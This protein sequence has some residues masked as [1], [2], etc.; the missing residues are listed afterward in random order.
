MLGLR[1]R[2]VAPAFHPADLLA[3][4]AFAEDVLAHQILMGGEQVG[5]VLDLLAEIAQHLHGALVGD[6][7]ARRVGKPAVAVHRHVLD[8]VARQQ[9]RRG[10]SR[11]AGADDQNVGL[12]SAMSIPP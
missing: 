8:A 5:L 1:Q 10:R 3:R 11:R 7:R 4:K 9:R 12:I 6:M 2:V